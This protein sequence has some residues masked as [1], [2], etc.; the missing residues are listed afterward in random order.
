[1][2]KLL[3]LTV[4]LF[5]VLLGHTQS[6]DEIIRKCNETLGGSAWDTVSNM[7]MN[8]VLEQQGMKIPIEV[9]VF[10]D[11]RT[12]TKIS[13]QGMELYQNVY[14]GTTLW[15]TNFLT[16]KPEKSD[17]ES[18]EN[19]KRSLGDFPNS[20]FSYKTNG[21]TV[22]KLED[23]EV[24]G[25]ACFKIKMT[26]KNQLV[27]GTEVPNVEYH[28]IDKD[29]FAPI[30]TETEIMAGEMKGKISQTKFSDYQ[31]VSKVYVAY[32]LDQGIKD[33]GSQT[34]DFDTVEINSKIDESLFKYTG[35]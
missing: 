4:T 19:F 15:S 11:G 33:L 30:M 14:D 35:E 10:R 13:I 17:N 31:E 22:E 26:K 1:M 12:Y 32:S 9:V 29:S 28:Y 27:D 3:L 34:I 24:D 25:V 20:F 18:T 6:V 2:K 21:Y 16:Q 23:D 7:K 8:A 5:T